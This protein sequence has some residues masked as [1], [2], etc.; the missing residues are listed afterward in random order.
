VADAFEAMTARRAYKARRSP[1]EAIEEL[2]RCAGSQF[3]PRAVEA[4]EALW[5]QGELEVEPSLEQL[6]F[7]EGVPG[8]VSGGT[9]GAVPGAV[10]AGEAA[11]GGG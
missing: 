11:G 7:Q 8:A 4:L 10:P 9:A 6:P 1:G 5:E 2:R 3:E